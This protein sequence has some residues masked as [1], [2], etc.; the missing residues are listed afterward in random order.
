MYKRS[1]L[2]H[3]TSRRHQ[4]RRLVVGSHV[5]MVRIHP[6]SP[7]TNLPSQQTLAQCHEVIDTL[8]QQLAQ[9]REQV[10]WLQERVKLDS[11]NSSKP[12]SSDVAGTSR[13]R[14]A[15]E[16]K[17]G[18]QPGHKGTYRV[19]LDGG[20]GRCGARPAAARGV[21]VRRA[22]R[23]GSGAAA[24]AVTCA[25]GWNRRCAPGW[26]PVRCPRCCPAAE[27][28]GRAHF[29]SSRCGSCFLVGEACRE[30]WGSACQ[31]GEVNTY[32]VASRCELSACVPQPVWPNGAGAM[33]PA[34]R[35]PD[36]SALLSD[37]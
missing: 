34:G 18:G 13:P 24:R 30:V 7:T 9:L 26:A 16:R 29:T 4:A 36:A 3:K 23:A 25:A 2:L 11:R 10:A 37:G 33:R 14:R 20:R 8:G 6:P 5:I 22:D 12:P 35:R 15:S 19:L 27:R 17:R 28:A 32:G 1:V 21:R 31:G